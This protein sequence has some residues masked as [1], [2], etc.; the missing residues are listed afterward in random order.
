MALSKQ[1]LVLMCASPIASGKVIKRWFYATNDAVATIATA[2]YFNGV[3]DRL[4]VND[5]IEVVAVADGTCD[6]VVYKVA[7]VPA[8]ADVTI[9]AEG[10]ASA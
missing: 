7:T 1:S 5:V 10:E 3:R 2:G 9:A 4:T 6:R 8:S